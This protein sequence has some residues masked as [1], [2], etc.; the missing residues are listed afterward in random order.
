[1]AP[2]LLLSMRTGMSRLDTREMHRRKL[3]IRVLRDNLGRALS[4]GARVDTAPADATGA[5]GQRA[6]DRR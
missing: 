5:P 3:L 2:A 4:A 6:V 1:M